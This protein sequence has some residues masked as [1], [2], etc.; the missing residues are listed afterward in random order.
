[1]T[2]DFYQFTVIIDKVL[3]RAKSDLNGVKI[4]AIFATKL[5]KSSSSWGLC[6]STT[7]MRGHLCAGRLG[8]GTFM[9][10]DF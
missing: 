9:C 6:G 10:R 5:Q 7:F 4:I 1:M 2:S 3:K 8:A